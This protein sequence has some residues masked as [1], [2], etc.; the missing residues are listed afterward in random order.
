MAIAIK[1]RKS[2]IAVEITLT[3][4]GHARR[5]APIITSTPQIAIAVPDVRDIVSSGRVL[6]DSCKPLASAGRPA[7]PINGASRLRLADEE[8]VADLY[9][10][11]DNASAAA[12]LKMPS[13]MKRMKVCSRSISGDRFI[14]H[15]I[16]SE[17]AL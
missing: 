2:N 8:A 9:A 11:K 6:R 4:D 1:I 16:V 13:E 10:R 7:S 12:K 3:G 15:N 5:I 17:L 14:F